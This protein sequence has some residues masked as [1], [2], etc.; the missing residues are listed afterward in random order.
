MAYILASNKL[1]HSLILLFSSFY[2]SLLIIMICSRVIS[3]SLQT[4]C[5]LSLFSLSRVVECELHCSSTPS[6]HHCFIA[7]HHLLFSCDGEKAEKEKQVTQ[8]NVQCRRRKKCERLAL[9]SNLSF[10]S[11]LSIFFFLFFTSCPSPLWNVR[12][13]MKSILF[14][15]LEIRNFIRW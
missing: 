3:F 15:Y 6:S 5:F 4:L 10:H 11:L 8:Y 7:I 14:L 1:V 12:I 13:A 9:H 2:F